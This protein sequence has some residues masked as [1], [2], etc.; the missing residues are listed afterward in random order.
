MIFKFILYG[1]NYF[2]FGLNFRSFAYALSI[3]EPMPYQLE[4]VYI[5]VYLIGQ[6]QKKDWIGFHTE[7]TWA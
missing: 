3:S 5:G 7:I 4:S 1:A 6:M 2:A